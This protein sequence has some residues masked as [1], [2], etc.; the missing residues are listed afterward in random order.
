[1]VYRL[2]ANILLALLLLITSAST[3]FATDEDKALC[4]YEK[5]RG[6]AFL[7]KRNSDLYSSGPVQILAKTIEQR[8]GKPLTQPSQKIAA[9]LDYL[10]DSQRSKEDPQVAE[11]MRNAYYKKYVTSINE[12]PES[13]YELQLRMAREQGH[14]DLKLSPADRTAVAQITLDDQ[15]KSLDEWLDYFASPYSESFPE[16]AK[17]WAFNGMTKLG[18]YEPETGLFGTRS[19]GQMGNFPELNREANRYHH[20]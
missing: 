12:V 16:W 14:G 5:L 13:F 7:H 20:C 1:M 8:T 11:R 3:V 18:K 6:A 17:Y 2:F 4:I 19:K 15:K 9:W 10:S